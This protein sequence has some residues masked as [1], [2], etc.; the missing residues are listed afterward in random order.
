MAQPKRT[1]GGPH[2]SCFLSSE[3]QASA[4]QRML[5]VGPRRNHKETSRRRSSGESGLH[6]ESEQ[7]SRDIA[8]PAP[9]SA[10]HPMPRPTAHLR[11]LYA[12]LEMEVAL[13]RTGN[14][15]Q[16]SEIS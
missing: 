7:V 16:S 15:S 10:D 8:K 3:R 6:G 12:K 13:G 11:A 4:T 1:G 2:R 14:R 5:G 9:I